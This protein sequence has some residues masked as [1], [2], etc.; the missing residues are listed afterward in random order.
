MVVTGMITSH[1]PGAAAFTLSPLPPA[2]VHILNNDKVRKN[3]FV[4]RCLQWTT[5]IERT[6][7]TENETDR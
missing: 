1:I 2:G 4:L 5:F 7:S 3:A 6:F